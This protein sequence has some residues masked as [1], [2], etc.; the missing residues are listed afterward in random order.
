MFEYVCVYMGV[1]ACTNVVAQVY[2]CV[3]VDSRDQHW[4]SSIVLNP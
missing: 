4:V 1:D 3:S 2:V